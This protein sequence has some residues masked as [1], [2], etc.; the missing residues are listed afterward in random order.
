MSSVWEALNS[1]FLKSHPSAQVRVPS[2]TS[3]SEKKIAGLCTRVGAG[4]LPGHWLHP[5]LLGEPSQ[6]FCYTVQFLKQTQLRKTVSLYF[7]CVFWAFK[8]MG[9]LRET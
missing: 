6:A 3:S 9:I 1:G 8:P 2:I 4:G 7:L 5:L